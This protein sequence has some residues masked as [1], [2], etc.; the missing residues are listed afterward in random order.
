MKKNLAA[1]DHIRIQSFY[2]RKENQERPCFWQ[3]VC[4]HFPAFGHQKCLV[5][6]K[7]V[8]HYVWLQLHCQTL[9][10]WWCE[11]TRVFQLTLLPPAELRRNHQS[12]SSFS[13]RGVQM[14]SLIFL[15]TKLKLF[16]VFLC[17]FFLLNT[18]FH[19]LRLTK[20][21][22][23]FAVCI[24]AMISSTVMPVAAHRVQL[25]TFEFVTI[26]QNFK[27]VLEKSI[28]WGLHF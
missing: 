8:M 10:I 9:F 12:L 17:L 22:I 5:R 13:A 20:P 1:S 7:C 24:L 18:R 25:N 14:K 16:A 6:N 23:S 21:A 2:S 19:C 11:V 28:L 15:L 4:Q 3:I 27:F 26:Y